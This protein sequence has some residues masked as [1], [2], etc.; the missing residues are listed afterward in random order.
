M[1][2]ITKNTQG[3]GIR[4]GDVGANAVLHTD[5]SAS[6]TNREPTALSEIALTGVYEI[7]KILA[8]PARLEVT[9][10]NV[11]NLLSSFMQMRDGV[12]AL[13]DDDGTPDV[14]VGAGWCESSPGQFKP[15]IPEK[16]VGQIIATAMPLVAHN[17]AVN[18][19]FE[20]A[21]VEALR[22]E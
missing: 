17:I 19:L 11:L 15:R 10:A 2:K 22:A 16:A 8:S 7:S 21:D 1:S 14:V 4:A 20:P 18:P 9:L 13:L 12:I 6:R 5:L 3:P